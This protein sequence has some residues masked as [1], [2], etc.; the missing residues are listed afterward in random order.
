MESLLQRKQNIESEFREPLGAVVKGFIAMGHS[1]PL[2]ADALEV[3]PSSVKRYCR[4][5]RIR[6]PSTPRIT[7]ERTGRPPRLITHQGRTNSITGWAHE[8]GVSPGSI[9]YRLKNG[10]ALDHR[11]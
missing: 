11:L 10:L 9:D 6:V 5:H 2:I 7:R 4:G 8:L 3:S 1:L